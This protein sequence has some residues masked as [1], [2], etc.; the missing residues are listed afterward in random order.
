MDEASFLCQRTTN[1]PII[2]R[3]KSLTQGSPLIHRTNGQPIISSLRSQESISRGK[4]LS[5]AR[6]DMAG[7]RWA[8]RGRLLNGLSENSIDP[9]HGDLLGEKAVNLPLFS[10]V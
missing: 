3:L 9:K 2:P 7:V 1:S 6:V 4:V 8:R 10:T 5:S